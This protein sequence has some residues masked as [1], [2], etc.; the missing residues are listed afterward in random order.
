VELPGERV[1]ERPP[2]VGERRPQ[3]GRRVQRVGDLEELG[4][5]QT[6]SASCSLHGR[7]DVVGAADA[8]AGPLGE[9]RADLVGLVEGPG[10][11]HGLAARLQSLGKA[12]RRRERGRVGES[13]ADLRELEQLQRTM[14]HG[15]PVG[16]GR[17]GRPLVP[18]APVPETLGW[19]AIANRQGWLAHGSPA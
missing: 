14:I 4:R 18:E 7:S 15:Q 11:D 9:E 3:A 12:S 10:D 8:D 1:E 13:L 19:P 16:R 17:R 6:P 5:V 2:V